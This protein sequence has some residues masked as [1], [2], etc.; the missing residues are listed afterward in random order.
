MGGKNMLF[1]GEQGEA[2]RRIWFVYGPD[3]SQEGRLQEHH[4]LPLPNLNHA[5]PAPACRG[6]WSSEI[7]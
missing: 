1:S 2:R 7:N 3:D 6:Q 4:T 5:V